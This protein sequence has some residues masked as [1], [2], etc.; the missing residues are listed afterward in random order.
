MP[1]LFL[2]VYVNGQFLE[3]EE[4]GKRRYRKQEGSRYCFALFTYFVPM[5]EHGSAAQICPYLF[6][7]KINKRKIDIH[8]TQNLIENTQGENVWVEIISPTFFPSKHEN[9]LF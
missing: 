3:Y 7:W 2:I 6:P 1:P 9:I 8:L 5:T 4:M